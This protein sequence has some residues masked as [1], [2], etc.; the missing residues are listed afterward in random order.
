MYI[1]FHVH[2]LIE[3]SKTTMIPAHLSK[4]NDP[5]TYWLLDR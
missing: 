1:P 4:D 5:T 3:L 2:G